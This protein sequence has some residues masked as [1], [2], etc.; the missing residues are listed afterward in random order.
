[1]RLH[2]RRGRITGLGAVALVVAAALW[3]LTHPQ[4]VHCPAPPQPEGLTEAIVVDAVDG[5]TIDV[6]IAGRIQRVR[7]IGVDTPELHDPRR[8]VR[9]LAQAAARFT[10]S[11]LV[12]RRV[13]LELDV[14]THDRYGRLLAYVWVDGKLV[15]LVL[16]E[17]GYA[18]VLTVPPNVRYAER[19]LECERIS[20]ERARGLWGH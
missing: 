2:T 5:D 14:Q 17:E 12:G 13:G 15:N 18:R 16:L 20:R 8:T 7:L 1:V 3:W 6:R 11:S 10:R 4:S 9:A 19:F